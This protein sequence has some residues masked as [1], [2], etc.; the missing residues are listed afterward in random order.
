[1]RLVIKSSKSDEPFPHKMIR[2]TGQSA[3]PERYTRHQIQLGISLRLAGG[4][5]RQGEEGGQSNLKLSNV[6]VSRETR[7]TMIAQRSTTTQPPHKIYISILKSRNTPEGLPFLAAGV[8]HV[9]IVHAFRTPEDKPSPENSKIQ[10][11]SRQKIAGSYQNYSRSLSTLP[12][13]LYC[14]TVL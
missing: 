1:M 9:C 3:L 10:A 13:W 6:T 7:K 11:I 8:R 2:A 5:P 12:R 4:S 14:A